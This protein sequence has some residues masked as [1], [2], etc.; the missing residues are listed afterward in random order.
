MLS[1]LIIHVWTKKQL[2]SQPGVIKI[3]TNVPWVKGSRRL[4]R[5]PNLAPILPLVKGYQ[6]SSEKSALGKEENLVITSL[7][8][9]ERDKLAKVR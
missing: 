5:L 8:E 9:G 3:L 7:C 6:D 1:E 2:T 4:K